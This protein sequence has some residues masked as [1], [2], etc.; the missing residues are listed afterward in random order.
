M[1]TIAHSKYPQGQELRAMRLTIAN[2][3]T[4]FPAPYI[5]CAMR[6]QLAMDV[7]ST[8]ALASN[9][10]LIKWPE[11]FAD[12]TGVFEALVYGENQDNYLIDLVMRVLI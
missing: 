5:M 4:I 10:L 2:E 6:L 8:M 1:L 3:E 9:G 12:R 7:G 11:D